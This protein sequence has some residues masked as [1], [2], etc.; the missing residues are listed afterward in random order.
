MIREMEHLS[1]RNGL[2]KVSN[3]KVCEKYVGEREG[4]LFCFQNKN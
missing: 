3:L 2:E 1:S 4:S